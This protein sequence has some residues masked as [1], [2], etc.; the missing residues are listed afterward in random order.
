MEAAAHFEVPRYKA[1]PGARIN[2]D[3]AVLVGG[4]IDQNGGD[5]SAP[6][7]VERAKPKKSPLHRFLTWDDRMAAAQHRLHEAQQVLGS[8]IV[9]HGEGP[10]Q[11]ERRAFYNVVIESEGEAKRTYVSE[12]RVWASEDL[13]GQVVRD[14]RLELSSWCKRF[15]SFPEL[16]AL[17]EHVR[18]WRD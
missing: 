18:A 6:E 9:V 16:Q 11:V 17:V 1:R 13:R 4:Y 14:A 5:L 8:I 12:R 7:F 15:E 3:D 2:N 10:S